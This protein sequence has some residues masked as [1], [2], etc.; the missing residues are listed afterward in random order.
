MNADEKYT[1][2]EALN[3]ACCD[4]VDVRE[5]SGWEEDVGWDVWV[6]DYGVCVDPP[7]VFYISIFD[8]LKGWY[9]RRE[10]TSTIL[11]F[12]TLIWRVL[13]RLVES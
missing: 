10:R 7:V 8:L 3:V 9:G 1:G 6:E 5:F 4:D 11:L 2:V 12:Q 13:G